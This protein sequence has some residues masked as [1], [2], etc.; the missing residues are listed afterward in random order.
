YICAMPRLRFL[1]CQDTAASDE[2]F[3]W[4]SQSQTIEYIWGRRC[5][6][7]RAR[8]FKALARM[9]KLHSLSVSCLNVDD[10][11]LASLSEFPA[12]KELMPRDVPDDGYRHIA[13]CTQLEDLILMY[14]R[15]TTDV[16]TQHIASL[17]RLKKYFASYNKITDRSLE[18][19]GRMKSIE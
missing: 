3:V 1:M 8:G 14:C 10:S 4:L 17:P 16:A 2:G 11:G 13:R 7:L 5:H 9:P 18:I 12:L 6:N 19:L 15:E